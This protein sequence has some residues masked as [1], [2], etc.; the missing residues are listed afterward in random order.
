[1]AAWVRGDGPPPYPLAEAAQDQL[2]ALA[3]EEAADLDR[4]VATTT[5]AWADPG[6]GSSS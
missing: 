5:E 6:V 4:P 1:M 2:V 3:I